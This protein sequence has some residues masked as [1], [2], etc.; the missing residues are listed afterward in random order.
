MTIITET[1]VCFSVDEEFEDALEFEKQD[2]EHIYSKKFDTKY[3]YFKATVV[4]TGKFKR[5]SDET[6]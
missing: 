3:F 5:T 6:E 1:T 2:V 4:S